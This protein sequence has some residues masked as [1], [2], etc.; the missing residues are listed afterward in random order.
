MDKKKYILF[1]WLVEC[2]QIIIIIRFL[3]VYKGVYQVGAGV[4]LSL[5]ICFVAYK[6]YTYKKVEKF[7]IRMTGLLILTILIPIILIGCRPEYTYEEGF[8]LINSQFPYMSG[9]EYQKYDNGKNTIPVSG[10]ETSFLIANRAYYYRFILND[11]FKYF[12]VD[13]IRGIVSETEEYWQ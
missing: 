5:F 12:I 2:I 4:V 11:E 10:E 13:P 9:A 7:K 3:F 1:I 8:E 6:L